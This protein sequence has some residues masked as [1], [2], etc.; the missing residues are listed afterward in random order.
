M[1]LPG[2]KIR[3][4]FTEPFKD[5]QIF[6]SVH[7]KLNEVAV[8]TSDQYEQ[9]KR[10]GARMDVV[11]NVLPPPDWGENPPPEEEESVPA[12]E[13]EPT[14]STPKKAAKDGRKA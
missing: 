3:V 6:G 2:M 9:A 4:K 13:P 7:F 5:G 8:L 1:D 14:R 12:S 10:S 11:G